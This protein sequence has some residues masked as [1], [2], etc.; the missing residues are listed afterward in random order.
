M[1]GRDGRTIHCRTLPLDRVVRIRCAEELLRDR[2]VVEILD[3]GLSAKLQMDSKLTLYSAMK[4]VR[5]SEAAHT[6]HHQLRQGDSKENPILLEEVNKAG[7][8]GAT[9]G[10]RDRN[11]KPGRGYRS[12]HLRN[13]T[14]KKCTRCGKGQHPPGTQCPARETTCFKCNRKGHYSAQCFSKSVAGITEEPADK[15][16]AFMGVVET[17]AEKSWTATIVVQGKPIIFKLDTGAE[18]SAISKETYNT[19]HPLSLS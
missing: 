17:T 15:D 3:T 18:V 12:T 11:Q 10:R 19:L 7:R 16:G 14:E 5:Q 9:G 4:Q 6:H 1:Q 2:I 8:G 13:K